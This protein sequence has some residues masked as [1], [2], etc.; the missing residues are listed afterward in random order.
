MIEKHT[1][2]R[3][4]GSSALFGMLASVFISMPAQAA[5]DK[6]SVL[7]A[8]Y[9]WGISLEGQGAIAPLPPV[10]IDA[11]FSDIFDALNFGGSL[12]TEINK[13]KWTFVIDPTYLNMELETPTMDVTL[14][15]DPPGTPAT[16]S[17]KIEVEMWFLEGWTSY[18]VIPDLEI[19]GGIRWQSQDITPS[20]N[21]VTLPIK[22]EE[23]WTDYFAGVR[24]SKDLGEKWF[25]KLRADYALAGDSESGSWNG[26]ALVSRRIGQTMAVNFGYRYFSNKYE[27]DAYLWDVDITGPMLGYTWQFGGTVF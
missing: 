9:L 27:T 19:L 1:T 11:S 10:D 6:W 18:E 12:H 21:G 22:V 3:L 4:L 14:P 26:V 20:I 15:P 17:G 16:V 7:L 25:M 5:E 24:W 13:G 8:P 23:N 2:C